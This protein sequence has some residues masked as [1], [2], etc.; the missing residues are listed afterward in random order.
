MEPNISPFISPMPEDAGDPHV[1]EIWCLLHVITCCS[2]LFHVITCYHI[3]LSKNPDVNQMLLPTRYRVFFC[4]L[5]FFPS[6]GLHVMLS[7]VL[8]HVV[9]PSQRQTA[10]ELGGLEATQL[11]Q[12][13]W[14][15]S[16]PNAYPPAITNGNGK[17][18]K[19][20]I[21]RWFSYQDLHSQVVSHTFQ[22]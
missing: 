12:G 6:A 19:W 1:T 9:E 14:S 17:W 22:Y 18:W 3:G 16:W 10:G 20:P 13:I 21:R 8:S 15:V 7:H 4:L 2:I 11:T 5:S